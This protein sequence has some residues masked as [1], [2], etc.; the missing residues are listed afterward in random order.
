MRMKR[1]AL[2]LPLA[3]LCFGTPALAVEIPAPTEMLLRCGAGYLLVAEDAAMDNT[4]EEKANLRSLG[5]TLLIRAD[6]DLER[7]GLSVA[8]R[9]AT[10]TRYATAVAE[11]FASDTDAG[12]EAEACF[13][14]ATKRDAAALPAPTAHA[15]EIDRLLS[16]A[17][18]FMAAGRASADTAD[19]TRL[20]ALSQELA[21]RA[22][23]L[24]VADGIGAVARHQIGQLHGE[25]IARKFHAGEDLPY[26][27]DTCAALGT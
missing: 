7:L 17:A 25:T 8:E 22:D 16:C 18:A 9:E 26:D 2:V 6:G 11:A 27:W 3:L 12:F 23:D 15:E 24:M 10:G 5:E 21:G 20:D 4:A 14:E 1:I 13:E 19:A